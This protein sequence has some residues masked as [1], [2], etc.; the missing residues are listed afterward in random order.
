MHAEFLAFRL[1][2]TVLNAGLPRWDPSGDY[3]DRAMA[4]DTQAS[5]P[6]SSSCM[7]LDLPHYQIIVL[8]GHILTVLYI[9]NLW[10]VIGDVQ[11][12]KGRDN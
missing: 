11:H 7:I 6:P 4:S 12:G 3:K 10:Q 2:F 8:E 5:Q 1:V 9:G